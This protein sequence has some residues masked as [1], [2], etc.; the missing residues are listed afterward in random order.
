[1]YVLLPS[2]GMKRGINTWMGS[3]FPGLPPLH[4]QGP[5]GP[6]QLS[7]TEPAVSASSNAD[8][9]P[10]CL[11]PSL[12]VTRGG[13]KCRKSFTSQTL[14]PLFHPL[15]HFSPSPVSPRI[16]NPASSNSV[17]PTSSWTLLSPPHSHRNVSV[18][19]A[20]CPLRWW[21]FYFPQCPTTGL[22]FLAPS[23]PVSFPSS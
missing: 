11:E 7:L 14:V 2:S 4:Q 21:Q 17:L 13:P 1:M 19:R 9:I 3:H 8:L 23:T 16:W 6:R 5:R 12:D 22:F 20:Y 18:S 10:L 15:L